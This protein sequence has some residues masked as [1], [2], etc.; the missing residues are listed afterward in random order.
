MAQYGKTFYGNSY[1]GNITAFSSTYISKAFDAEEPFTGPIT[2]SLDAVLTR[3]TYRAQD[4]ELRKVG[5]WSVSGTTLRTT[6]VGATISM[7]MSASRAKL[8]FTKQSDVNQ[9]FELK[10]ATPTGTVLHTQSIST[11]GSGN[12]SYESPIFTYQEVIVTVTAKTGG[13]TFIF[14]G[15]EAVVTDVKVEVGAGTSTTNMTYSPITLTYANGVYTG[16]TPSVANKRYVRFKIHLASS[17][18]D[19]SPVVKYMEMR[20]GDVTT[21]AEDGYWRASIN[22]ENVAQAKSKTFKEVVA[23]DW[24]ENKPAATEIDYRS[25]GAVSAGSTNLGAETAVYR[26]GYKRLRL[27]E[28]ITEGYIVTKKRVDPREYLGT[29]LNQIKQWLDMNTL[30]S[31]PTEELGQEIEIS[32]YDVYPSADNADI[33]PVITFNPTEEES[34]RALALF[35]TTEVGLFYIM[36]RLKRL[37]TKGTPVVDWM[38]FESEIEFKQS[39]SPTSLDI[40]AIDNGTGIKL[41]KT[42]TGTE[43]SWPTNANANAVN[44]SA[45]SGAKK[46]LLLLDETNQYG[47]TLYFKSKEAATQGRNTTNTLTDAIWGK[48]V[49]ED[50]PS[51]STALDPKKPYFHYH[52]N[53]STVQYLIKDKHEMGTDYTPALIQDKKYR[54]RIINGRP[55]SF[56]QVTR[57]MTWAEVAEIFNVTVTALKAVN[58]GKLEYEGKLVVGQS[59]KEPNTTK[60]ANVSLIFEGKST[61]TD[62]SPHNK[63]GTSIIVA[64]LLTGNYGFTE[65]R[66]E[67]RIYT[68][69]LNVNDLRSPYQREQI[70]STIVAGESQYTVLAG[71]TYAS[72]AKKK[73]VHVI[74]LQRLNNDIPLVT[75]SRIRVPSPLTLPILAPEVIFT[76][77]AGNALDNPYKITIID[78]S[79][80]K[81]DGTIIDTN[82]VTVGSGTKPGMRYDIQESAP[83]SVKI[84]RGAIANGRDLLEHKNVNRIISIVDKNGVSYSK[85]T[86]IGGIKTGDYVMEGNYVSWV[87]QQQ[88]SKEPAAGVEYTVTYTYNQIKKV[89]LTMDSTYVEKAGYDIL[90]RSPE[91]KEYEGVARPDSDFKIKI[92]TPESFEGYTTR[93]EDVGYVVEDNDIWVKTYIE[94]EEDGYYLI[95]TMDGEDPAKNWYPLIESGYYYLNDEERYLY[96][97]PIQTVFGKEAV[98]LAKNIKYQDGGIKLSKAATNYVENGT[99]LK[100]SEGLLYQVSPNMDMTGKTW[101]DWNLTWEQINGMNTTWGEL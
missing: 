101:S 82:L 27:P 17:D 25:R 31:M 9:T 99:F 55:D 37:S 10:I 58:P 64:E 29:N 73:S 78:N 14:Q 63:N 95:G 97:E 77:E 41:L 42:L 18:D 49:A 48:L 89:Y 15:I 34:T 71:D 8:L 70:N 44:T 11:T 40:S 52:Y 61:V 1:Y 21:R 83:V 51:T 72:I 54:Y 35:N 46:D 59:I 91:I 22:M 100:T 80:K 36:I 16:T 60:N 88:S 24:V 19:A 92:A 4:A 79:V 67:Q 75:G 93:I 3:Q 76:D 84:T 65:W 38:S 30:L 32:F 43:F 2:V 33:T 90:W 81:K 50:A 53:G 68:G 5:A 28:G 12:G 23:F 26:K 86:D 94:Q 74:D 20:S 69:Y 45:L 13:G 96:S 39:I 47:L 62:V 87:G 56:M 7:N 57:P 98:P 6:E 85:Y 66:S